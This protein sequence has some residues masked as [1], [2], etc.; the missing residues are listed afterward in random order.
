[1][2]FNPHYNL[3]G[4]HA[5][6]SAS[7]YH[8]LNYDDHKM[9]LAFKNQQAAQR[10]TDL[11]NLASEAIRLGVKLRGNVTIAKYVNDCI[12]WGM[13]PEVTLVYSENAFG[14]ADAIGFKKN[15]LRISD[16]K[17][18]ISPANI[19]QLEIYAAFFC[20]EYQF[21][22]HELDA[23]ELRIYQNDEVQEYEGDAET[24][25][26]TMDKIVHFD[27]LIREWKEAASA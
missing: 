17:T 6:L 1:M 25:L 2:H 27:K 15:V 22:P 20:L 5:T 11:H 4:A 14:T 23:M 8:W 7:K 13:S 12:G 18:G 26:R 9:A 10:G 3:A 21:K 19:K 16:L 24:V